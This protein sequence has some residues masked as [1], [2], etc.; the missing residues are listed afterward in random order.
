MKGHSKGICVLA[1]DHQKPQRLFSGGKIY[2]NSFALYLLHSLG[3]DGAIL[4]WDANV[5]ADVKFGQDKAPL[6]VLKDH[7]KDMKITSLAYSPTSDTLYSASED[8]T[9]RVWNL[10]EGKSEILGGA[11]SEEQ[12]EESPTDLKG[13]STIRE[14]YLVDVTVT[15]LCVVD[16]LAKLF[17]ATGKRIQVYDTK[18]LLHVDVN[19]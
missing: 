4:V 16:S 12:L 6:K 11:M 3:L 2:K 9:L 15:A 13:K 10:K 18:V 17:V 19:L 1:I 5:P 14:K 8:K 7:K